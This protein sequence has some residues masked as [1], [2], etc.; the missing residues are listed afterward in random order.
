MTQAMKVTADGVVTPV[1][2]NGA[3]CDHAR[4]CWQDLQDALLQVRTDYSWFRS[5]R[6]E[7]Q[8]ARDAFHKAYWLTVEARGAEPWGGVDGP[9]TRQADELFAAASCRLREVHAEYDQAW[10]A[11]ESAGNG[12][13]ECA[14]VHREAVE[15][16]REVATTVD[17]P[18][19]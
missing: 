7:L 11:L 2:A 15:R 19:F 3:A 6:Q 12:L 14:Q 9:D 18:P 13:D 4:S 5:V 16:F 8:E 1:T 17:E 10:N